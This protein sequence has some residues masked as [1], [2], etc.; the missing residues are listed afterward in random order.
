MI[1]ISKIKRLEGRILTILEAVV[2][3]Q[4]YKYDALKKL[5]LQE[6]GELYSYADFSEPV[7]DKKKTHTGRGKLK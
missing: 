2:P 7:L 4:M 1:P 5:I 3:E 6:T